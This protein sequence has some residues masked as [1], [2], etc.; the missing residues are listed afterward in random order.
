M[1]D[2]KFI[3]KARNANAIPEEP[4][5]NGSLIA[6]TDTGELYVDYNGARMRIGDVIALETEA[7]RIAT[8]AP[9]PKLYWVAETGKLWRFADDWVCVNPDAIEA[10]TVKADIVQAGR[11]YYNVATVVSRAYVYEIVIK[12]RIPK[13]DQASIN[14]IYLYGVCGNHVVNTMFSTYW[15]ND[16][17][18]FP[19]RNM[20]QAGSISFEGKIFTYEDDGTEY[21]GIA[22]LPG[23]TGLGTQTS[24]YY[25]YFQ[26]DFTDLIGSIRDYSKGWTVEF[27]TVKDSESIIPQTN[28]MDCI[29][30]KLVTDI[31]GSA[32]SLATP[33]TIALT[34]GATGTATSFDGTKNIQIPVTS[35]NPNN[36][37]S[38]V[39]ITKGGTGA[40]TA[41]NARTALEAGYTIRRTITTTG[42]G[43]YRIAA[44]TVSVGRNYTDVYIDTS[45]AGKN[46]Q[47]GLIAAV[48]YGSSTTAPTSIQLTQKA[49]VEQYKDG[50]TKARIVYVNGGYSGK[51]AYL[52][53]YQAYDAA[54]T[55]SIEFQNCRG[56]ATRY[57]EPI[58]GEIPDGYSA[59]EL[60][61]VHNAVVADKFVGNVVG[62]VDF[63]KNY[64]GRID[65]DS[66]TA[67]DFFSTSLN[68]ARTP[69][70]Y[71]VAGIPSNIDGPTEAGTNKV[72]GLLQVGTSTG[73]TIPEGSNGWVMQTLTLTTDEVYH[74][75]VVNAGSWK[76]W[77]KSVDSNDVATSLTT[78]YTNKIPTVDAAKT[79]ID[80]QVAEIGGN[81]LP[82][83][84]GTLTGSLTANNFRGIMNP[85]LNKGSY[86]LNEPNTSAA[87]YIPELMADRLQF[88]P[89]A[90]CLLETSSDGT[91]WTTRSTP[92]AQKQ[93]LL[94]CHPAYTAE[95]DWT[96]GTQLRITFTADSYVFLSLL[97][98]Y[99]R[100]SGKIDIVIEQCRNA[101]QDWVEVARQEQVTGQPIHVVLWHTV[102][103]FQNSTNDMHSGKVRVTLIHTGTDTP[104]LDQLRW[105]GGYPT[106][107]PYI[108]DWD[109]SR[110][111]MFPAE[112]RANNFNGSWNDKAV[113]SS[114]DENSTSTIPTCKQVA[115]YI[116]SL[117]GG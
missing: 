63:A 114:F 30:S 25:P 108:Y 24:I 16:S 94:C 71:S 85:P 89:P 11:R 18:K 101:S 50:V 55:Y 46:S 88:F 64:V 15:Q 93:Q 51:Y 34:G 109:P 83:T 31:Y 49:C 14:A 65:P 103:R 13:A 98:L 102:I 40:T 81:Y 27:N 35:L 86:F 82:L 41:A 47:I 99:L 70:W 42:A 66:P 97:Y 5:S 28:I 73:E 112:V 95:I 72:W 23:T 39:P 10:D 44:T 7:Q 117:I 80:A 19:W 32:T 107:N 12:T 61:F 33:R 96:A 1:A 68:D 20:V 92:N 67:P 21:V 77:L 54:A 100:T 58:A 37:S 75:N 76:E 52:E 106:A 104:I 91:S 79:Y 3:P 48:T 36:L 53:I 26:V 59:R 56:W 6:A 110:N 84:G 38:A 115:D 29:K 111:V 90:K 22:L 43:W 17:V 60:T 116:K 45:L 105:K 69:G 113:A 57:D 4:F 8:L 78:S 2:I 87:A 9:L 74:R 62:T